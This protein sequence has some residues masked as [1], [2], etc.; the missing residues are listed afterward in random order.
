[1]NIYNYVSHGDHLAIEM[2]VGNGMCPLSDIEKNI[3][4][5]KAYLS[6]FP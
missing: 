5:H 4:T 3:F 1:M 2:A 6:V